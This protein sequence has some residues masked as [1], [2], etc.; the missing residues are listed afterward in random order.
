MP[1]E[2]QFLDYTNV[3]VGKYI[4]VNS[5]SEHTDFVRITAY[6]E[7]EFQGKT[8]LYVKL[9]QGQVIEMLFDIRNGEMLIPV[10]L[11]PYV[12]EKGNIQGV[13]LQILELSEMIPAELGIYAETS[14]DV[15]QWQ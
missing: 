15:S 13:A 3:E 4:D 1:S 8:V 10:G 5:V 6:A 11:N 12:A 7:N 9:N 14:I 2:K